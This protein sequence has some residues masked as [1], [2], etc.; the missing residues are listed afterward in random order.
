MDPIRKKAL[1]AFQKAA[2]IRFRSFELLDLSFIHRSATNEHPI[3][4][5]NER[6]EFLGDAV[7]GS[8]AATILYSIMRE[9]PEGEL[10]RVKSVIVSEPTLASF[11]LSLGMDSLLV[12]GKGEDSS[13]GRAKKAI[14]ADAFEALVGALYLDSGYKAVSDFVG[15]L[16]SREIEAVLAGNR[17]KDHKTL[18]QEYCQKEF[19]N[20]PEYHLLKRTGP[21]HERVFWI[22]VRVGGNVYGPGRGRNKKEAEQEAARIAIEAIPRPPNSRSS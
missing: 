9:N 14:L 6:L 11:A 13:G 15:P 16:L 18:L 20:Y 1:A 7:L 2:M 10:A 3:R 17:I 19:R 21:D 4:T 22:E 5:N 12:L 8:V